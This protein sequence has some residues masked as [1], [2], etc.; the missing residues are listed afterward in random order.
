MRDGAGAHGGSAH[1]HRGDGGACHSA[2]R[3]RHSRPAEQGWRL[4]DQRPSRPLHKGQPPHGT[5]AVSVAKLPQKR[6]CSLVLFG[7]RRSYRCLNH[8][9][10]QT[11]RGSCCGRQ[12]FTGW[13]TSRGCSWV[14][15]PCWAS[16]PV[17]RAVSA[18]DRAHS[19]RSPPVFQGKLC[20]NLS[21]TVFSGRN[22]ESVEVI[23]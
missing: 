2:Q 10:G 5:P 16:R 9:Q 8:R 3:E 12:R 22:S 6:E 20:H 7:R 17:T 11:S 14:T 15:V 13:I 1:A 18:E 4:R 21:K 23:L 19:P